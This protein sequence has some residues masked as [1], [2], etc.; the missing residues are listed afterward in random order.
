MTPTQCEEMRRGQ[1]IFCSPPPSHQYFLKVISCS[2]LPMPSIP[3]SVISIYIKYI[4]KQFSGGFFFPHK[5]ENSMIMFRNM[6]HPHKTVLTV[7]LQQL[8]FFL[9]VS[10]KLSNTQKLQ[11]EHVLCHLLIYVHKNVLRLSS[12]R[13]EDRNK[14]SEFVV[15]L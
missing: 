8:S 4:S 10:D 3:M 13:K 1:R 12:M 5:D 6:M 2:L 7:C 9:R 15:Y 14:T 11:I